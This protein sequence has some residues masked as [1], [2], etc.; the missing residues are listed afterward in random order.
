MVCDGC[1]VASAEPEAVVGAVSLLT[2]CLQ[3]VLV[4]GTLC[5]E[6]H[7]STVAE[8]KVSLS[9]PHLI[10]EIVANEAVRCG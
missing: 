1:G 10:E 9:I 4:L 7:F 6:Q 8:D 3:P 5:A 2:S